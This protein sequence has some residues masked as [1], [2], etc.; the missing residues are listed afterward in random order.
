MYSSVVHT[1][2]KGV[3]KGACF[4]FHGPQVRMEAVISKHMKLSVLTVSELG[5]V[6]RYAEVGSEWEL[7]CALPYTP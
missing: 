1:F 6:I 4:F 5:L 2:E 7:P 3:S